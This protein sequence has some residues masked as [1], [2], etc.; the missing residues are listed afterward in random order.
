[1]T[2]KVGMPNTEKI[3]TKLRKLLELARQ[4]VGGEKDNAQSVLEKL[5]SKH[6]LTLEDLDSEQAEV[7]Q[8]EFKFS[9]AQERKL[10]LQ[11][12]FTVLNAS[13][14]PVRDDHKNSKTLCLKATRAQALEID[15]AW[16]LYRE[17]FKKEQERLFV[18]FLHKNELFGPDNKDA[19]EK[20]PEPSK[21]SKE[22]IQSIAFMVMGMKKTQ[23][24]KA[25]PSAVAV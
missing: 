7:V 14:I 2:G 15:L 13:T 3:K 22:D 9:D 11:V 19:D 24:Y 25:L 6:G 8:C 16:G 20:I 10:L 23:V 18:A 12:I 5:L 17:S 4:G 1:M 21:L